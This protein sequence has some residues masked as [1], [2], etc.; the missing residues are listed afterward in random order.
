MRHATPPSD[1]DWRAA[2]QRPLATNGGAHRWR[3]F[4]VLSPQSSSHRGEEVVQRLCTGFG[5]LAHPP[6]AEAGEDGD[7]R[8]RAFGGATGKHF[9]AGVVVFGGDDDETGLYGG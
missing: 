3:G 5:V 6:V 4:L 9:A 1:A 2:S 8:L 7:L